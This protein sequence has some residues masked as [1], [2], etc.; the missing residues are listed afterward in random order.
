MNRFKHLSVRDFQ[1]LLRAI[2]TLNRDFNP[3]T[4]FAR[5]FAAVAQIVAAGTTALQKRDC[6]RALDCAFDDLRHSAP[7]RKA[8][9]VV[10][11][12]FERAPLA[13]PSSERARDREL[14]NLLAPHLEAAFAAAQ[15]IER[16]RRGVAELKN[17]FD[18][19]R[20]AI[21]I[22]DCNARISFA[23]EAAES[24]L[25]RYCADF[26]PNRRLP[27]KIAAWIAEQTAQTVENADCRQFAPLCLSGANGELRIRMSCDDALNQIALLL[28]E[29][30]RQTIADFQIF[31][32][33]AREAEILFWICQGKSDH[34][35]A[36]LCGISTRTVQKHAERILVK[37]NVETRL[38]A[39]ALALE[40]IS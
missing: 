40:R 38:A 24:F 12:K 15:T 16:Q 39:A 36:I 11:F 23:T 35:I 3:E 8:A 27:G 22:V 25:R 5:A 17:A 4:L 20:Q 33:T 7:Q 32:L 1:T 2:E 31:D 28:E 10:R 37:L 29:R 26:A 9:A 18:R 19:L 14:L 34:A 30:R 21:V 13:C 6:I